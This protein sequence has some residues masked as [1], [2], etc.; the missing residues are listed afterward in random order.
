[1][2]GLPI[3][4][5]DAWP[6]DAWPLDAWPLWAFGLM[7]V[8]ARVGSALALLPGL[9]ETAAPPPVRAG[10]ALAIALLLLPGLVSAIP[11]VPEATLDMG[12]MVAAEVVTGLWF[13]WLARVAMLALPI[14]LQYIAYLL[15]IASVLQPDPE[16]GPQTTALAHLTEIAAPLIILVS[17]MYTMPLEALAGL[18]RLV[19]PGTLIPLADGTDMA[20]RVSAEALSLALRLASPFVLASLLWHAGIGLVAR[21]VPRVQIYFVSMPGQLLGGLLLLAGLSGA[22]LGAWRDATSAALGH[23]PGAG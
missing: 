17:G 1:M 3:T 13:G 11:K 15:G 20:L 5:A 10:L 22:V 21:L 12:A 18:Y 14:G 8:L 16:L 4:G 9:G 19:P 23:L 7:L 2:T 6:L